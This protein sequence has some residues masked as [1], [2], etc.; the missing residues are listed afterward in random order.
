MQVGGW[1]AGRAAINEDIN[2]HRNWNLHRSTGKKYVNW[3]EG[4]RVQDTHRLAATPN[5]DVAIH[6]PTAATSAVGST[7]SSDVDTVRR[8]GLSKGHDKS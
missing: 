7:N 5:E 4:Q 1:A 6:H 3:L 2:F 8:S